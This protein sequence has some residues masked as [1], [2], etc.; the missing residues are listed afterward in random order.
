MPILI[1]AAR[2]RRACLL[3]LCL[4]AVLVAGRRPWLPVTHA[5]PATQAQQAEPSAPAVHEGGTE[6]GEEHGGWSATIAKAANFAMLAGVLVYFLRST[7]V[8]YLN[9]RGETIRKDLV[10]A[11]ALRTEAQEQLTGIQAR[12]GTLPAEIEALKRRGQEDLAAERVRLAEATAREKERVLQHT[13]REIELQF[14][15]A[16]RQLLEHAA[17]LSMTLARRRIERNITPADQ[18]RLVDRYAAEVRS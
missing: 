14:R 15:I 2:H 10:D 5:A 11:A 17:D 13:R 9:T 12:L 4:A 18:A 7:V 16:R 1:A 8:T 3:A 6:A